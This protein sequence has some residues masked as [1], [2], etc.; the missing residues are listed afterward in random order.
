MGFGR[1]GL[2]SI[3]G[4][5]Y[6]KKL[7]VALVAIFVLLVPSTPALALSAAL[8]PTFGTPISTPGGFVVQIT[9]YDAAFSWTPVVSNCGSATIDSGNYLIVS[10][11][12]PNTSIS[13]Q[14]KTTRS[15]YDVGS[16]TVSA[17]STGWQDSKLITTPGV[18]NT[19]LVNTVSTPDGTI[20]ASMG[21]GGDALISKTSDNGATWTTVKRF[22]GLGS[23][24]LAVRGSKMAL[25]S[26]SGSGASAT[27]WATVSTDSGVTWTSSTQL[28][29][30]SNS[31]L[32]VI[33]I[34]GDGD[35]I[36][37][38]FQYNG[39]I[40]T[41]QVRTTTDSGATWSAAQSIST[42]SDST[43]R[44]NL[45]T[46]GNG[47]VA[48]ILR[49]Y[50][51]AEF[52]I[53]N[54]STNSW[55]T[56]STI[57]SSIQ[58]DSFSSMMFD[59]NKI[60]AIWLDGSG[61]SMD[62]KMAI[63]DGTLWSSIYT[64]S[65][66]Q[67]SYM[68]PRLTVSGSN[69]MAIW[70][71]GSYADIYM[72][73][74]SLSSITWSAAQNIK[75]GSAEHLAIGVNSA[76]TFAVSWITGG[77]LY[78][79]ESSDVG[80]T[81]SNP[82]AIAAPNNSNY[83]PVFTTNSSGILMILWRVQS[84]SDL[85]VRATVLASSLPQSASKELYLVADTV[86]GS[87][88]SNVYAPKQYQ[89]KIYY[90]A[91]TPETGRELFVFNG[92]S[93]QLVADLNPGTGSGLYDS[94]GV[95]GVYGGKLLII[96]DNGTTGWELYTYDG[97]AISL[98][99]NSR[100][101]VT[102]G[103]PANFVEYNNRLY[104]A[105]NSDVDGQAYGYVWD[106]TNPPQLLSAAIAGYTRQYFSNP[107]VV[108]GN[109]YFV[110]RIIN[111]STK[112]TKFD[113]TTVTEISTTAT[114]VSQ[115][116]K[117][118][119][120]LMYSGTTSGVAGAEPWYY[121]GTTDAA[122]PEIEAGSASS[123]PT[124]FNEVCGGV[125]MSAT[126]ATNGRELYFWDGFSN[127]RLISD[128][129]AGSASAWPGYQTISAEGDYLQMADAAYG[130]E[131]WFSDG[132]TNTRLTDANPGAAS[133]SPRDIVKV[134]DT[135]YMAGNTATDGGELFAYGI[136]PAGFSAAVYQPTFSV[137]YN[138]NTGSGGTSASATAGNIQ[139]NNGS[140]FSKS[141]YTLLGWDAS[142]SATSPTFA[143]GGNYNLTANTT[144][145]AI[146]GAT[147]APQSPVVPATPTIPLP[148]PADL[149]KQIGNVPTDGGQVVIEGAGLGTTREAM[150][151]DK[152]AEIVNI[153]GD[154]VTLGLP[155]Q[156]AGY[157][158][159]TLV[160]DHG[161]VT[162]SGILH[163]VDAA[164]NQQ[165]QSGTWVKHS[166]SVSGFKSGSSKLSPTMIKQ[167]RSK[168][169][170]SKALTVSCVGETSGPTVLKQDPP[171]AKARAKAVCGMIAK[172]LGIKTVTVSYK[173]NLG[174]SKNYRR[175]LVSLVAAK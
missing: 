62:V 92:T 79:M 165:N 159:L 161:Q 130:A 55:S 27:M 18:W 127:P 97:T 103:M 170:Y 118:G 58:L 115:L 8:V 67:G 108:G 175:V 1:I 119:T 4:A 94:N 26:K 128:V 96:A 60:A 172:H 2:Y 33:A 106:Y 69:M 3:F 35:V 151:G 126:T 28:V 102:S 162:F 75:S 149:Q 43:W 65:S 44:V 61:S 24:T 36:A 91:T 144:L 70:G 157:Y 13:V 16:A 76:Q 167:V 134:G 72:S 169:E 163:Y 88:S 78:S 154:K 146:W 155:K 50:S 12:K 99:L 63:Y 133:F 104:F 145:Y 59:T 132:T 111:Q 142:A 98:L 89:G 101:G 74:T 135:L 87:G 30:P 160:T 52:S 112:L 120:Y 152:R 173:N 46:L 15:G 54:D 171:L 10:G 147:P 80:A 81:W 136:K 84:A 66:S 121:N 41:I 25:L 42:N 174:K 139:L 17:T 85:Q 95:V 37:S 34:S 6:M 140:G 39:S 131:L 122:L 129:N 68:S 7:I 83:Q 164:G 138:A 86:A 105:S 47:N 113:G 53:Y 49:Q 150:A 64:V 22:T 19:F 158:D 141:G 45:Q 125:M 40:F 23:G 93:A 9:N 110:S 148:S 51:I 123:S 166:F 137:S 109:L 168:I 114:S 11:A 32:P 124:Q 107:T 73:K 77:Y 153:A 156:P 57:S 117:F 71:G 20:Y 5:A 29:S 56:R 143:V 21:N 100:A 48:A 90:S 38:W 31:D 14:L 116:G 82:A